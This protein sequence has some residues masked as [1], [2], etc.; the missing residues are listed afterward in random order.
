MCERCRSVLIG[1]SHK[2]SPEECPLLDV[3]YC[4]ICSCR[5]H[6]LSECPCY[7]TLDKAQPR[8][9][10]QLIPRTLLNQYKI[11]TLTPI[12]TNHTVKEE[13]PSQ[14]WYPVKPE[15]YILVNYKADDIKRTL[16]K[17]KVPYNETDEMAHNVK[18]L[19][20]YAKRMGRELKWLG[21]DVKC[22]KKSAD[23]VE[24]EKSQANPPLVEI[25]Q[26]PKRQRKVSK[27]KATD[28]A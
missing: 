1:Y 26:K 2:H 19:E 4:P 22:S 12:E 20:N 23:V 25:A 27:T 13:N 16:V 11:S 21:K 10:E 14:S 18:H 3:A 28:T 6:Y 9:L 5:G 8:Y 15:A 7:D 24:H 17:Y